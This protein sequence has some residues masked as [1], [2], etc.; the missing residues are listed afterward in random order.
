MTREEI[1]AL[2]DKIVSGQASEAEVAL[3]NRLLNIVERG[4]NPTANT[5]D[6]ITAS[7][8]WDES[9]LGNRASIEATIKQGIDQYIDSQIDRGINR[10]V[11]KKPVINI[12]LRRVA[13]AAAVLVLL[14][15]GYYYFFYSNRVKSASS[16]ENQVVAKAKDVPAPKNNRATITLGNGQKLFLDSASNGVLATQGTTNIKKITNGQ[17][18]YVNASALT[19]GR[20]E[21]KSGEMVYNTLFNPRG[22]KIIDI[23]LSDGTRVWLNA[24]SSLK[25]PVAFS[26][27]ER[28]VEI[29]GEAY[30]EVKH[31]AA[32]AFRVKTK[33]SLIEDIGTAFN[34]NAYADEETEKTT[35]IQG[36][37]EVFTA[38]GKSTAI[39][40]A[41]LMRLS[42]GQ[43]A[44][45]EAAA[46]E[47][48][49][50]KSVDLDAVIAW[51]NNNFE[52]AGED[53][54]GV[55]RQLSRW[56]DIDAT[57]EGKIPAG[58]FS[59]IVSRGSN[60]SQVLKIME[61]AD[62]KFRIE[63]KKLIVLP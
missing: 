56:Y 45:V 38:T 43:Q 3:Y 35:L 22:S 19:N 30:F 27:K 51:K 39:G 7:Q 54:Q 37:V 53:I 17:L 24:E 52:F 48:T 6:N 55:M 4:P 23:T 29:I 26:G 47:I 34:V 16:P 57:Y 15:A 44:L 10:S 60:I 33:N 14:G 61:A 31:D 32:K 36:A 12:Y 9:V 62:I 8:P 1:I 11:R 28:S 50:A 63:G 40:N 41:G 59:G 20:G 13:V 21:N 49:L 58:H 46:G 5:G 25:Y 2:A 18:S 42:P